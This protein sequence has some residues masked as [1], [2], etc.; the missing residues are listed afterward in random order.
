MKAENSEEINVF[1]C[2]DNSPENSPIAAGSGYAGAPSSSS[3]PPNSGLRTATSTRLHHLSNQRFND[4]LFNNIDAMSTKGLGKV[5][6]LIDMLSITNCYSISLQAIH[7]I[8]YRRSATSASR[9]RRRRSNRSLN[10]IFVILAASNMNWHR[11]SSSNS[12]NGR[13]M[14]AAPLQAQTQTPTMTLTS[15]MSWTSWCRH[16][17][18][19]WCAVTISSSSRALFS[20]CLAA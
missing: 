10:I 20:R 9:L 12:S 18:V 4:P 14:R 19:P 11:R 16:W 17:P 3:L 7:H 5:H 1:L 6:Q 8:A 2:H 15:T 13:R